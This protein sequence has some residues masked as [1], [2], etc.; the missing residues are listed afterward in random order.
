MCFADVDEQEFRVIF[1]SFVEPLEVARLATKGRSGIAS[2]NQDNRPFASKARQGHRSFSSRIGQRKVRRRIAHFQRIVFAEGSGWLSSGQRVV[3]SGRLAAHLRDYAAHRESDE[4]DEPVFKI[5]AGDEVTRYDVRT[6][7]THP[8][9]DTAERGSPE[10]Q[11]HDVGVLELSEPVENVD[12]ESLIIYGTEGPVSSSAPLKL[13]GFE[14]P[15][16]QDEPYDPLKVHIVEQTGKLT[17][18]VAGSA[19]AAPLYRFQAEP[20]RGLDGA[21]VADE[22][23][24][25]LGV[26]GLIREKFHLVPLKNL[27]PILE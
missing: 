22:E 23:G 26:A 8:R 18:A 21:I 14:N 12:S 27:Q 20:R 19:E 24:N 10:W 16:E 11:Q 1:V 4:P 9:F 3:T 6:I 7:R 17:S 2:E 5:V 15:L 13:F 25:I